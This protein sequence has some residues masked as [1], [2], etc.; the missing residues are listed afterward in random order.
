MNI[1]FTSDAN[2]RKSISTLTYCGLT[3]IFFI[4]I[5][6]ILLGPK[7]P[8]RAPQ[9]SYLVHVRTPNP[10]RFLKEIHLPAYTGPDAEYLVEIRI[11]PERLPLIMTPRCPIQPPALRPKGEPQ[12]YGPVKLAPPQDR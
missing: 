9:P 10:V 3:A 2:G 6:A 12:K 1:L 7:R 5:M 8:E 11:T 4:A